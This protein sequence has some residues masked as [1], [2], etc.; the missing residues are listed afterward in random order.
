MIY[1]YIYTY[2]HIYVSYNLLVSEVNCGENPGATRTVEESV[3]GV[4]RFIERIKSDEKRQ[5]YIV[6][7]CEQYKC[8]SNL[9]CAEKKHTYSSSDRKC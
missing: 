8:E 4:L 5:S 7:D 2:L 9:F 1:I 6:T 3:L